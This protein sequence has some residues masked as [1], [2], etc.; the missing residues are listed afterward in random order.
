MYPALLLLIL[1]TASS[2]AAER[3]VTKEELARHDGKQSKEYWL[4]LMSEVY[5]VTAG[6]DE[7][8]AEGLQYSCFVGRDANVPFIT[9][10]FND[11]EAAKPITELTDLQLKHLESYWLKFYQDEERYPFVGYLVGDL[12][13]EDGQ[14][15]YAHYEI[16]ERIA[17]AKKIIDN[18]NKE[19]RE[20][21][22]RRNIEM[23]I[24]AREEKKKNKVVYV[25]GPWTYRV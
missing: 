7:W 5:D 21:I 25:I 12:Y 19:V 10:V 16:Q 11:T 18:Q 17:E 6:A 23:E 4:S 22:E 2:A 20:T 1:F 13:D 8:Y 9:G 15:T 14:T 24:R 3:F